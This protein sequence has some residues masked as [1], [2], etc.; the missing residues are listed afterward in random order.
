MK[1]HNAVQPSEDSLKFSSN[2]KH[3]LLCGPAINK[4]IQH[5]GPHKNVSE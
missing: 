2:I 5:L 4:R 1:Q 3:I